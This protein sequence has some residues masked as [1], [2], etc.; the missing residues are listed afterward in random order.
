MEHSPG[1]LLALRGRLD[2][3]LG[4]GASLLGLDPKV[5]LALETMK[6]QLDYVLS[7]SLNEMI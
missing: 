2:G 7:S 1:K 4:M 6:N 5:R 3:V